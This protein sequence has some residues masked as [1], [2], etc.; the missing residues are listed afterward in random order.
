MDFRVNPLTWTEQ[1][2]R[3]FWIS[4]WANAALVLAIWLMVRKL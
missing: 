2:R 1:E 3:D 4:L